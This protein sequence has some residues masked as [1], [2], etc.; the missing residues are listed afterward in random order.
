M[1]RKVGTT[2]DKDLYRRTQEVARRQRRST[3]AVIEDALKRFLASDS[4]RASA[5]AETKGLFK[6]SP[7]ALRVVLQEDVYGVE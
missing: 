1:K 7:R 2:L 3:N 4:T 6:V 5:V